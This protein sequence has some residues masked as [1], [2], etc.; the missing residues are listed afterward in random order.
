MMR[1]AADKTQ[2]GQFVGTLLV[3]V[4][5]VGDVRILHEPLGYIG[6]GGRWWLVPQDHETDYASVPPLL[7]RI[8]PK[9][10]RY[11]Y[12]AVLHDALYV[13]PN[14]LS[15]RDCDGV[16]LESMWVLGVGW[17]LRHTMWLGVRLGGWVPWARYRRADE[18]K[19]PP[20]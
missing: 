5:K 8:L 3:A 20:A 4:P 19:I 18:E 15:R 1:L 7:D 12:A 17:W 6:M 14:G 16:F 2:R 11:T 10:G 9:S 13:C